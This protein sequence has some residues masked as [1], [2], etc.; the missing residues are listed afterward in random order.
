[1]SKNIIVVED[2]QDIRKL[3]EMKIGELYKV[4]SFDNGQDAFRFIQNENEANI[5]LFV[6]DRM[7]PFVSGEDLTKLIRNDTSLQ[8]KPILMLTALS[9]KEYVLEGF[10][11]GADDYLTKPFDLDELM[12]RIKSLLRR[13]SSEKKVDQSA[14]SYESLEIFPDRAIAQKD[15]VDISLTKSE[16]LMLLNLLKNRG[17]VLKRE[18]LIECIQGENTFVTK[19]TI[20]T[21]MTSL[22]KK[23]KPYDKAIETVRGMGY[24]FKL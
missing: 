10:E 7:L 2:D 11:F 17:K 18:T 13:S 14:Y 23:I 24:R 8:H 12:A 9:S 1:M 4:T 16:Y 21:H 5:D 3:L 19:R 22:R 15:G 6:L 20:D